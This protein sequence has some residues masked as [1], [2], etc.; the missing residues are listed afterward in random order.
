MER[1]LADGLKHMVRLI[2]K[3]SAKEPDPRQLVREII[4]ILISEQLIDPRLHRILLEATLRS[5]EVLQRGREFLEDMA[6]MVEGL[7]LAVPNIRVQHKTLAAR[8]TTIT[9][10]LLTHWFVLYG[11][12]EMDQERFVDEMTDL[13]TN[14]LFI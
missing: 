5:P 12:E 14:Y 4:E 2:G 3:A 8:L 7:L 1:H 13:L 11:S 10:F 6:R 9:G